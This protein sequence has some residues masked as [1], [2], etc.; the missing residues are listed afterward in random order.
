M[1]RLCIITKTDHVP[2][3]QSVIA[4]EKLVLQVAVYATQIVVFVAEPPEHH[5]IS[6]T[7]L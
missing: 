5:L 7:A 3:R 1:R 2:A 4:L 6:M